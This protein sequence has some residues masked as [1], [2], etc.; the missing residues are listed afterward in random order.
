MTGLWSPFWYACGEDLDGR[1][2]LAGYRH[3]RAK[4]ER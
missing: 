4:V 3:G 1:R 2:A